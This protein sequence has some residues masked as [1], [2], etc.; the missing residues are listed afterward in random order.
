MTKEELI[1]I[2]EGTEEKAEMAYACRSKT[3]LI[4]AQWSKR[5]GVPHEQESWHQKVLETARGRNVDEILSRA[6]KGDQANSK[7]EV[8]E[9]WGLFL[10]AKRDGEEET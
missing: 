7:V 10:K 4:D 6:T 1:Q 5:S 3:I 8:E 9:A 2:V